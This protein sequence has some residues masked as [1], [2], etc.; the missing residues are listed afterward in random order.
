MVQALGEEFL[1]LN[2]VRNGYHRRGRTYFERKEVL[3]E[4]V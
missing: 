3:S 4:E 2:L 1:D